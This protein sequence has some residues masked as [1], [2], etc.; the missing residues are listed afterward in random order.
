MSQAFNPQEYLIKL[1]KRFKDTETGQWVTR[2]DDYLEVKWRLCWFRD[3]YPHGTIETEELCVDLDRGYARYKARVTDGE[4]G[5]AT[6]HGTETKADFADYC[7]RAETR[8]LGRALAAMGI[9]TQFVGAELDELPHVA[10]APVS[11]TTTAAPDAAHEITGISHPLPVGEEGTPGAATPP[12]TNGH[13]P[14]PERPQVTGAHPTPEQVEGLFALAL[15]SCSEDLDVLSTRIRQVMHLPA[16][17]STSKRLLPKTMSGEQFDRLLTYYQT[18][19]AQLQRPT[20]VPNGATPASPVVASAAPA[21][22]GEGPTAVPSPAGLWSANA[23]APGEAAVD[24]AYHQLYQEALGWGVAESE[25]KHI[26][27]HHPLDQSRVILWKARRNEPPP[28]WEKVEAAA[29]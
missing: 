15:E 24:P 17:A 29:D 11:T 25:I 12:A 3:R 16:N 14:A 7:E 21:P 8:A 9:G 5:S 28:V 22:A 27:G 6:G 19:L 26:L 10:D 23:R 20:E 2:Y 1:P 4:G 18:L 13:R